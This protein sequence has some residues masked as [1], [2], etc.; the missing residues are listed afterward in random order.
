MS[1]H[2]HGQ[3]FRLPVHK[4]AP[5]FAIAGDDFDVGHFPSLFP[6]L[7]LVCQSLITE[8]TPHLTMMATSAVTIGTACQFKLVDCSIHCQ[9][10]ACIHVSCNCVSVVT[11]QVA[12]KQCFFVASR[13]CEMHCRD[14]ALRHHSDHTDVQFDCWCVNC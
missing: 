1:A 11:P 2:E 5:E 12:S 3:L 8:G 14:P 7:P 13:S 4:K 10:L 6:L 9:S